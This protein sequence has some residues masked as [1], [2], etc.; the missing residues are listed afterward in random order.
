MVIAAVISK[1]W[2]DFYLFNR[3]LLSNS[4]FWLYS[5]AAGAGSCELTGSQFYLLT[6]GTGMGLLLLLSQR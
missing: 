1:G 4:A 3:L 6:A 2:D 5:T